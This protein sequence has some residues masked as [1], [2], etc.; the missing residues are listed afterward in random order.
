VAGPR[1]RADSRKLE[2][3]N[4]EY[5]REQ[6][7]KRRKEKGK[8]ARKEDAREDSLAATKT[9]KRTYP[10][11]LSLTE[12]LVLESCRRSGGD[13]VSISRYAM[14]IRKPRRRRSFFPGQ[15][16]SLPPMG[17]SIDDFLLEELSL[18]RAHRA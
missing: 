12:R 14:L 5:P 4:L 17:R 9:Q 13:R 16:S 11:T 8:R 15:C 18:F 10:A 2:S 3:I 6:A 7:G 1:F